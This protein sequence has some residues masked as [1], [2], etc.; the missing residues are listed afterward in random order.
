[1][2]PSPGRTSSPSIQ[3]KVTSGEGELSVDSEPPTLSHTIQL[4]KV[5]EER[6]SQYTPPPSLAEFPLI[7][8]WVRIGDEE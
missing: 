3:E 6:L 4:V 5:G 2:F 7:V 8:L 1:M